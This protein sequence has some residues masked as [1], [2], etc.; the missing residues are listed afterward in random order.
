[1]SRR[2]KQASS[3]RPS[4]GFPT[5]VY[6]LLLVTIALF[7]LSMRGNGNLTHLLNIVRQTAPAG[8]AAIG[9]TLALLG[10][11]IDLSIGAVINLVNVLTC[12]WMMGSEQAMVWAA[13]LA[14]AVSALVGAVNGLAV[15]TARIPPFLATMAMSTILQ[16]VIYIITKGS[17]KGSIAPAFRV[18]SDGWLL[19][20]IPVS[21]VIWFAIWGLAAFVLYYTPVGRR[22]YLTGDNPRMAHLCGVR[23]DVYLIGVYTACSLLAGLAGL[24]LS[25]YIGVAS[26]SLGNPYTLNTIAGAVIGGATFT[27]GKGRLEGTFAGIMILVLLQSMLTMLNIPEAGKYISQGLVIALMVGINMRSKKNS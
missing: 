18:L 26:T 19:R 15:T 3:F 7:F 25:A 24:I 27:G 13:L 21:A 12:S 1:M 14:L 4:S 20:W 8:I 9:Q 16:G 10:G 2:K 6:L 11:G 17:P 23:S 5:G 22:L